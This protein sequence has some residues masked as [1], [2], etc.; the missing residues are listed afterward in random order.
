[1]HKEEKLRRFGIKWKESCWC[2]RFLKNIS[3][4]S[5]SVGF[6]SEGILIHFKYCEV[7]GNIFNK[8]LRINMNWIKYSNILSICSWLQKN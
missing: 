1:M 4:I 5:S 2:T 8:D 7:I 6:V 3:N